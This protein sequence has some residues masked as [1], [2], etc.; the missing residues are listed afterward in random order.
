MIK[1]SV[2]GLGYVGSAMAVILASARNKKENVFDV[3]GFDLST[4]KG[5]FRINKLNNNEFPFKTNDLQI[6]KKLE[7]IKKKN[8]LR[9][10]IFNSKFINDSSIILISTHFD[11]SENKNKMKKSFQRY[12]E[13]F[14]EIVKNVKKKS[15]I[16]IESTLP[17]GFI[18]K[19]LFP[20]FKSELKKRKI[21]YNSVY[22]GYSYERVTPGKNYLDS[23]VN[24]WR[25]YSGI[26]KESKKKCK[27]F[28]EKIINTKKYPLTE[29]E[30]ITAAEIAKTMENSY[31]ATNIAFIEE[32][33]ILSEKVNVDLNKII[34]A[35]K[36]RP[37]HKNMMYPGIGVGGYCLTKDPLLPKASADLIFKDKKLKFKFSEEAV[38]TNS[39]MPLRS[40]D[41]VKKEIKN[42]FLNKKVLI[43]GAAYKDDVDDTRNSPSF[44]FYK[45]L[46]KYKTKIDIHDPFVEFW[47][48]ANIK[49]MR[50]LPDFSYYNIIVFATKHG[51]YRKISFKKKFYKQIFFDFN[52]VLSK[53]QILEA[54]LKK[55]NLFLIGNGL[56]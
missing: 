28:L 7:I 51:V 13:N 50:N 30:N 9:A 27:S 5:I 20:I 52:N 16:I 8:N 40:F 41:I 25:V 39:S 2:I 26:N 33:S 12:S 32:W 55:N 22:L 11:Y 44:C 47:E 34:D 1:L 23:I 49:V 3:T 37:T 24:S 29:L 31:R 10:K 46:K 21:D 53:K 4:K 19:I 15:L 56:I 38:K 35:I 45:K 14:R 42:K 54:K 36:L 43:C 17:P 18:D 6:K 48:E